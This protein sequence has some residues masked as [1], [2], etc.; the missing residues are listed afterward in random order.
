MLG[1]FIPHLKVFYLIPQH[2]YLPS[3][4]AYY[5][6]DAPNLCSI[7]QTSQ[8]LDV[9]RSQGQ[10]SGIEEFNRY[11]HAQAHECSTSNWGMVTS[12]GSVI[13]W[14]TDL[15][16][17]P[18]GNHG[19][20]PPTLFSDW[21]LMLKTP[22]SVVPATSYVTGANRWQQWAYTHNHWP[23]V[24]QAQPEYSSHSSWEATSFVGTMMQDTSTT[25]P[26]SN[27]GKNP[28]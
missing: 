5:T 3:H 7:P 13:G 4:M 21:C 17:S 1:G 19:K 28:F 10:V 27:S 23:G 11:G 12:P 8:G 22:E 16:T 26:C 15:H 25:I 18:A 24:S 2:S 14:W 9:C 6:L 20:Y